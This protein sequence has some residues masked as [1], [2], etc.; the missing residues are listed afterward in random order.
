MRGVSRTQGTMR[1]LRQT[2]EGFGLVRAVAFGREG[3]GLRSWRGRNQHWALGS[4]EV[5]YN[6]EPDECKQADLRD[7]MV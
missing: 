1:L 4:G 2:P 3:L 6:E 5:Q 7:K